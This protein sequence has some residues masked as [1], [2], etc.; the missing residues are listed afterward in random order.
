M[1]AQYCAG[2]Q[3]DALEVARRLRATLV[4]QH[5]LD[6]GRTFMALE[7]AILRADRTLDHGDPR[8]VQ[9]QPAGLAAE[10]ARPPTVPAQLPLAPADFAGRSSELE[11]LTTLGSNEIQ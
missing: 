8:S 2:R 1:L 4:E 3:S 7:R 6:P 10:P 11:Q 9:G 5:G